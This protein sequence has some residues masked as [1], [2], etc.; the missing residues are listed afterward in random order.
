MDL[1]NFLESK[2][3]ERSDSV[4]QQ[5]L[6]DSWLE[7]MSHVVTRE[8]NVIWVSELVQCRQKAEFSKQLFFVHG[9]KPS[10]VLGSLVHKGLELYLREE[11]NAETEVEFEKEVEEYRIRGKVDAI[12][13]DSVIEI[14]YARGLKD[15]KPYEHHINQLR[16]YLWLTE[17]EK[18]KLVYITPD[19]LVEFD[20]SNPM[21]DDEVLMLIDSWKSPRYD[22]ECGYCDFNS[23]CPYRIERR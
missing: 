14:K 16:L 13:K 1:L 20:F 5:L 8:D 6:M 9:I 21:S 23:I 15:N 7:T 4:I 2:K 18:G 22:W 10:L 17:L 12:Y 19:K 11:L 3:E